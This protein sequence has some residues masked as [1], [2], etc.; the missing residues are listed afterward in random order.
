MAAEFSVRGQSTSWML[1]RGRSGRADIAE[2]L[3]LAEQLE[4]AARF[5][6]DQVGSA[7]ILA[8]A[9]IAMSLR[10]HR[11][12]P[13]SGFFESRGRHLAMRWAI[14]ASDFDDIARSSRPAKIRGFRAHQHMVGLVGSGAICTSPQ[15]NRL[16]L[17]VP[18]S[19]AVDGTR[20][21]RARN[22][23]KRLCRASTKIL[24]QIGLPSSSFFNACRKGFRGGGS[25][26]RCG[27][28]HPRSAPAAAS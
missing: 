28:R 23:G 27:C 12:M 3:H 25:R 10:P 26:S 24:S 16:R 17:P 21:R 19:T 20:A 4:E 14:F 11:L 1:T 22:A 9:F 18:T 13:A 8:L 6:D 5:L 7:P 2:L 15:T